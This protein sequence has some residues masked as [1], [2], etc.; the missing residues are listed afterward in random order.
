MIAVII[1]SSLFVGCIYNLQF[2]ITNQGIA[3]YLMSKMGAEVLTSIEVDNKKYV[4]FSADENKGIATFRRG[5]SG[6]Y[7]EEG[8]SF[9]SNQFQYEFGEKYFLLGGRN[10]DLKIASASVQHGEKIYSM[11]IPAEEY[12][13]SYVAVDSNVWEELVRHPDNLRFYNKEN[14]DISEQID[15][16]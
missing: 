2:Y 1:A 10:E 12:F 16:R 15:N 6:K 9:S 8:S 5:I 14:I 13:I 7:L 4:M 11:D 3:D